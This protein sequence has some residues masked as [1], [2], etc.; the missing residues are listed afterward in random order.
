MTAVLL[1]Y[2]GTSFMFEESKKMNPN[3]NSK[4]LIEENKLFKER[5]ADYEQLKRKVAEATNSKNLAV[6]EISNRLN[7]KL[8]I[9]ESKLQDQTELREKLEKTQNALL[10]EKDRRVK[11]R[12]KIASAI[13]AV[14]DSIVVLNTLR[15]TID[16]NE[17]D[18]A[19]A[20]KLLLNSTLD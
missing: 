16:R 2:L 5:L 7:K 14:P 4:K 18:L 1:A 9:V 15:E 13:E 10:A 3:M 6:S 12:Q 19:I 8:H 11:T 20:K 17:K